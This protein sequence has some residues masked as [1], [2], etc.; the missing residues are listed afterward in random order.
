MNFLQLISGHR[1][2]WGLPHVDE[3]ENRLIQIC[4]ECGA[5]RRVKA[6]LQPAPSPEPRGSIAARSMPVVN[7]RKAA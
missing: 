3:T 4:Y 1:H 7:T 2:Y 6:D 5:H